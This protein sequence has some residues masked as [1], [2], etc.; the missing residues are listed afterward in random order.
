M[1][2]FH[3]ALFLVLVCTGVATLPVKKRVEARR[4]L[5]RVSAVRFPDARIFPLDSG[6]D[7]AMVLRHLAT[8]HQRHLGFR[9]RRPHLLAQ[10]ATYTPGA[11]GLGTLLVSGY[12]RGRPLKVDRIVHIVGHGDFQLRQVDAPPDPL[13]LLSTSRPPKPGKGGDVEMLVSLFS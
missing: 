6:P 1:V 12:V 2:C 13:P 4:S 5:T 8:Q 3:P 9:S 10:R 11:A 7:A